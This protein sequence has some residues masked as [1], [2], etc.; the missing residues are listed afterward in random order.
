M[1]N[2]L[3]NLFIKKYLRSSLLA[4]N[5]KK[6]ELN[7]IGL[8]LKAIL[9]EKLEKIVENMQLGMDN[10]SRAIPDRSITGNDEKYNFSFPLLHSVDKLE[11]KKGLLDQI[12]INFGIKKQDKNL[13]SMI[14][15]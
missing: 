3:S 9:C 8:D 2:K 4:I 6:E 7:K 14:L 5:S 10:K 11:L 12:L 13:S 15:S 1:A